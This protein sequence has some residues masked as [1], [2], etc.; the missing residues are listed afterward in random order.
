M[1]GAN[2]TQELLFTT[3]TLADFAPDDHPLREI[4]VLIDEALV[5]TNNLFSTLYPQT[6][7]A[8]IA[9]KKLLR[10]QLLQPFYSIRSERL[11]MEQLQY[12]LLFRWF[13]GIAIDEA[14]WGHSVFSKSR[15]RLNGNEV[16]AEFLREVVVLAQKRDLMS[17]EYF[18]VDGMLL[19]AW[20]SHKS[21]CPKDEPPPG[22]G[23][24]RNAPADFKRQTR[25][26]D[27]HASASDPDARLYRKGNTGRS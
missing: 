27:T 23:G 14:V 24:Q 3:A 26:N 10:A 1:R 21:F 15:D 4:R 16:A 6:G 25:K 8:S 7:R 5:R 12:N 9:S 13:V 20:A 18:S 2:I 22:A 17:D 19:Q 11:L